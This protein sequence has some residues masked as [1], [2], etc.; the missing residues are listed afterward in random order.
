MSSNY[1]FKISC[2]GLIECIN[3]S[4]GLSEYLKATAKLAEFRNVN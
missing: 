1:V 3:C 2:H 4:E